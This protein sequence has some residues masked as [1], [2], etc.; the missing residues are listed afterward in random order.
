LPEIY[1]LLFGDGSGLLTEV[2]DVVLNLSMSMQISL[3][4]VQRGMDFSTPV[5]AT[6]ADFS[7]STM[8]CRKRRAHGNLGKEGK[9]NVMLY[10]GVVV[11]IAVS[12]LWYK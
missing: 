4:S 1:H 5:R 2:S 9:R 12:F 3:L 10:H 11:K 7:E 6:L 8:L